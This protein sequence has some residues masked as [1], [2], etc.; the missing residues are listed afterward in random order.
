MAEQYKLRLMFALCVWKLLAVLT[1]EA[2]SCNQLFMRILKGGKK[3]DRSCRAKYQQE[4]FKR[5]EDRK[6]Y[7]EE[8]VE[9]AGILVYESVTSMVLTE[10]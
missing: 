7:V 8:E 1:A 9:A 10:R 2:V 6:N 4:R 3:Q 5:G